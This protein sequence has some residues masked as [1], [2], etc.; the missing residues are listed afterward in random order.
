MFTSRSSNLVRHDSDNM[1]RYRVF[2]ETKYFDF[3]LTKLFYVPYIMESPP[4]YLIKETI[5]CVGRY[6]KLTSSRRNVRRRQH[7]C[8]REEQMMIY[9]RHATLHILYRINPEMV[10]NISIGRYLVQKI[11]ID[12]VPKLKKN[13]NF[14]PDFLLV[15]II[16]FLLAEVM[17]N[18]CPIRLVVLR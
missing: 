3:Y 12:Y 6:A 17:Q 8:N 10:C 7:T 18:F 5:C 15:I 4:T 2:A 14:K 1:T 16:Y 11:T 9:P 13:S